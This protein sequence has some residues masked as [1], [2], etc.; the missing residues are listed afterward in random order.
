MNT[1]C[2]CLTLEMKILM[3][4]SAIFKIFQ[5]GEEIVQSSFERSDLLLSWRSWGF[6]GWRDKKS[7]TSLLSMKPGWT[8]FRQIWNK[9]LSDQCDI[10][11]FSRSSVGENT[12]SRIWSRKVFIV[13]EP[14]MLIQHWHFTRNLNQK[15]NVGQKLTPFVF[16]FCN[17]SI[18]VHFRF[19]SDFNTVHF[20]VPEPDENK[21]SPC[22]YPRQRAGVEGERNIKRL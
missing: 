3:T 4:I 17:H 19:W 18:L 7:R 2:E 9:N 5:H 13:F 14:K 21:F 20:E 12:G 10:S 8:S 22:L 11:H 1:G 15:C 6:E 16:S